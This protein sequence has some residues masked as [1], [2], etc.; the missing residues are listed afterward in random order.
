MSSAQVLSQLTE[1]PAKVFLVGMPGCGKSTVGKELAQ[2]LQCTFLDLDTLIEEQEGLAVPQVFEQRGQE[3]FRQAEAQALR[4][5]AARSERLV[6]A[7]GGGAPCFCE[8]MGFMVSQ[9]ATVYLKLT[10]AELVARL[11]PSDL[12][13]RPLL[14][15]KTPDELLVYLADTLR[16]REPFY[17]QASLVVA[18]GGRDVPTV[19]QQIEQCLLGAASQ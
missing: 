5:A 17:Q 11:T 10:P 19:A 2:R 16:Q 14:R 1:L 13:G 4:L 18:A 6:L 7:T 3:Y 8:N 12:Q 15:D 9:G